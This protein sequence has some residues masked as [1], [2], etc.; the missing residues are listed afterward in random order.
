MLDRRRQDFDPEQAM[1]YNL[2]LP[3]MLS[4]SKALSIWAAP[5]IAIFFVLILKKG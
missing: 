5:K 3:D 4:V 1:P 2:G